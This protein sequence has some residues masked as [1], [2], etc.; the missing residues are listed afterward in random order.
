MGLSQQKDRA[1]SS[2]SRT[3][4]GLICA[5]GGSKTIPQ[6]NITMVADKPL[7][8]WTILAAQQSQRLSQVLVSTDDPQ[9]AAIAQDAGAD[10]PFLRPAELSRDDTPGIDP[11][12]HAAHWLAEQRGDYPD[13]FMVLQPTSPLRTAADIDAA[14]ELAQQQQADAV[15]SVTPTHHHPYWT[16]RIAEDGTLAN[17]LPLERDY[18]RRQELPPAYA[19]NGAIYLVRRDVLLEQRTYYTPRTY[20]YV[21]PAERSLDVDSVW[22]LT[23]ARCVLEERHHHAD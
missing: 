15:V 1:M 10:V 9:I 11:V 21:M 19:L 12:I 14:I 4:V 17:F 3:V 2:V 7:I 22:D 13:Y 16:K 5:R 6:K 23:L 20:A 18:V 8:V